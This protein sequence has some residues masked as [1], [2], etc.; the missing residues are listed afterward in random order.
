MA[1]T[2][3]KAGDAKLTWGPDCLALISGP[4]PNLDLSPSVSE[5]LL[6]SVVHDESFICSLSS[7]SLCGD[8]VASTLI[9]LA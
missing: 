8:S 3:G 9:L 5:K 7:L 2:R 4:L 1:L 6:L